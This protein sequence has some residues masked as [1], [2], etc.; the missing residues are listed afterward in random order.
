MTFAELHDK[1]EPQGSAFSS[2]VSDALTVG[3]L[4]ISGKTLQAKI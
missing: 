1:A 3:A 4:R 2:F